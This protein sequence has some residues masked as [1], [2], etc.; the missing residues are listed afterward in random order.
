[1]FPNPDFDL[2][3]NAGRTAEQINAAHTGT[4]TRDDLRRW[5][6]KGPVP[7]LAGRA[8][9]AWTDRLQ[10]AEHGEVAQLVLLTVSDPNGVLPRLHEFLE[11]ATDKLQQA[12]AGDAAAEV[13]RIVGRL[14]ELDE[15]LYCVAVDAWEEINAAQ[16]RTTAA[17]RTS[18]V[19]GNRPA[20]AAAAPGHEPLAPPASPRPDNSR[21]R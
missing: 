19:V 6:V 18:P 20:S 17:T 13:T 7:E 3:D 15:D 12:G 10:G 11:A 2:Y 1:M 14:G 5:S 9:T 21:S 16:R 8:I 4:P